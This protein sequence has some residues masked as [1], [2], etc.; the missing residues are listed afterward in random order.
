[1]S[2][3][4]HYLKKALT[5]PPQELAKKTANKLITKLKDFREKSKDLKGHSQVNFNVPIIENTYIDIKKID[6]SNI[7]MKV[8][9]YLTKRCC[10]HRFDLL[11]SGWVKNSYDS[12]AL[13]VEGYRYDMNIAAPKSEMDKYEPIDWQKDFKS[14][15]RWSQKIWYKNQRIGH[16][17]GSDIKVPWELARLQHLPQLAIFS[18]LDNGLKKTNI[19]EF[20]HQVLDFIKHNPPRM[21]VNWTCAMDVGI[22]A[23]NLLLA[24]DLFVQLDDFGLLDDNFKKIFSNSI[25]AHGRHIINNLEYSE[26]LTSNHYLSNIVGLLYISTYLESTDEIDSW[27]AF[28]I[29]EIISEM[30]NEFY[31]DGGNFESSTSYHRLSGELMVFSTALILGLGKKTTALQ[32]YKILDWKFKPKLLPLEQQRY[33]IK[34]H[35]VDFP[36]WYIDRLFK[37]G[38]FTVDIT[39]PNEKVPQFGDNDSGRFFRLSPNGNFLTNKQA[40][41]KYLNLKGYPENDKLFWDEHTLNHKTFVSCFAGLYEDKIFDNNIFLEKSLINNIAKRKL[42][43][44][45][46]SYKSIKTTT[47]ILTDVN[48]KK[49]LVHEANAE[50]KNLRLIAYPDSGIYLF[51]AKKF[52]LAI[53]ATPLGQNDNGGHTH[54]DKLGYELWI[55]GNDMVKDPGTYLYTPLPD[56]RNE[57][58]SIQAHPVPNVDEIE[59]NSWSDGRV[60]LFRMF[61]ES[62]CSVVDFGNDFIELVL[63]YKGIRVVR[64]FEIKKDGLTIYDRCNKKLSEKKEFNLYSNGYGKISLNE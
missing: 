48:N 5:M 61:R 55:D 9:H 2:Q 37:I 10:E 7:D 50:I 38:R 36:Q 30:E 18:M 56:R 64:K 14:G 53:C 46:K 31:E 57:F 41:K 49:S 44:K 62:K 1:M 21:G 60:G 54:N 22:R 42:Q 19:T 51:K 27:L 32:N 52:Y 47:F 33:K 4:T 34:N 12:I 26:S 15:F 29:Q 17:L 43:S 28:S 24:Y 20:K 13:G 8:A 63:E 35:Q 6:I 40:V 58:R 39:K 16:A 3:L 45:D 23:A 25:Y 59:Q 11:G